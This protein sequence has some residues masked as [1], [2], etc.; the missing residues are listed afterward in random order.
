MPMRWNWFLHYRMFWYPVF[1]G[2]GILA[3]LVLLGDKAS[4]FLMVQLPHTALLNG[5]FSVITWL[6]DGFT[7]ILIAILWAL[8][9]SRGK[10][11]ALLTAYL[12]GSAVVQFLKH[13]IFGQA[14]RP[15]KWFE[16]NRIIVELPEGLVVS[17]WNS[18]PSGHSA[19]AITLLFFLAC[20][21]QHQPLRLFLGL[22]TILAG[23]SRIYLYMH[24]PEDV[25]AGMLIGIVA[26]IPLI[27]LW[28]RWLN[29]PERK[30]LNRPFLKW[31]RTV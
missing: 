19:T 21:I 24:F 22:L 7:C 10:S 30:H 4:T 14:A 1:I 11:F 20:Q 15:V 18:F 6:G 9:V 12:A 29:H 16:L 26:A 2:L 13:F 31:K 25:L 28:E 5:L 3:V 17:H 23:Y 27:L 8:F